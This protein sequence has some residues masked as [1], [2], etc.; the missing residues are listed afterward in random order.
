MT[1]I[2]S[3]GGGEPIPAHLARCYLLV[4]TVHELHR[5]GYQRLR[6]CPGMSAS[7]LYWRTSIAPVSNVL[8]SNGAMLAD[9]DGPAANYT[10]ADGRRFFGWMDVHTRRPSVIAAKFIE[11]L[12]ELAELGRG[13]DW[14][15]AGWYLELLRLTDPFHLPI[16]YSDW[17]LDGLRTVPEESRLPAPPPGEFRDRR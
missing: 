12:P 7:G 11:R 8:E 13:S 2:D 15:Y 4:Q 16:A 14:A 10:S 3:R 9:W 5:L 6:L 17:G 1:R